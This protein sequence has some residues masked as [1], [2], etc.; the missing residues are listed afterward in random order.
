MRIGI[1]A[2]HGGFGLKEDLR[3]RLTA[4]GHEV[5]DFGANRLDPGRTHDDN[6]PGFRARLGEP[7]LR[8]Q[9]GGVHDGGNE[10]WNYRQTQQSLGRANG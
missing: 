8:K 9:C 7:A 5:V 3:G 1:A 10:Q 2:D 4:A 6:L